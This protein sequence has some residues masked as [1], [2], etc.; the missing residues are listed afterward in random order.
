MGQRLG[1]HCLTFLGVPISQRGR[2]LAITWLNHELRCGSR[3]DVLAPKIADADALAGENRMATGGDLGVDVLPGVSAVFIPECEVDAAVGRVLNPQVPLA[4]LAAVLP[5]D[6]AQ[7]VDRLHNPDDVHHSTPR[8][9][10][11]AGDRLEIERRTLDLDAV[12]KLVSGLLNHRI[13]LQVDLKLVARLIEVAALVSERRLA[14]IVDATL[15]Y[16]VIK[17]IALIVPS[18]GTNLT[19]HPVEQIE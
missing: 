13:C 14:D 18:N 4:R 9:I 7:L 16:L 8:R 12:V 15:F 1:L 19:I 2:F 6:G 3:A 10:L 17:A 11:Q 5:G